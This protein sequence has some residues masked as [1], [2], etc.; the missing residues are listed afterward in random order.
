MT[1]TQVPSGASG[2]EEQKEFED[3]SLTYEAM[4]MGDRK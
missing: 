1:A 4:A 2:S 3:K